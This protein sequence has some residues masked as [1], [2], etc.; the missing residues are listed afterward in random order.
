[1]K[2]LYLL[3]FPSLY[4]FI[5]KVEDSPAFADDALNYA[6]C[7]GNWFSPAK[8]GLLVS[9][10]SGKT[11]KKLSSFP[12]IKAVKVDAEGTD[13]RVLTDLYGLYYS[14]DCGKTWETITE[15][16]ENNEEMVLKC[17]NDPANKEVQAEESEISGCPDHKLFPR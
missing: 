10:D 1:M 16:F 2:I 13:L 5:E 7:E 6:I 17:G 12:E 8:K 4:F 15:I 11:W 9:E 14:C 3:L